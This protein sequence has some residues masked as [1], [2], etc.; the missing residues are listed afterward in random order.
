MDTLF[1]EA[2]ARLNMSLKRDGFKVD[3]GIVISLLPDELLVTNTENELVRL[4]DSFNFTTSKTHLVQAIKNHSNSNWAAANGQFRTFIESLLIEIAHNLNSSSTCSDFGSAQ[5]ELSNLA[6][7][8]LSRTLNEVSISTNPL[9]KPY[10]GGLW[11]RLHA[12]GSHPGTSDEEDSTFRYHTV[13]VF[14][15]YLLARLEN[16]TP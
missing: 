2:Y 16:R 6:S 14:A 13:S 1:A 9:D 12:A 11:K 4:L 7:P 10:V 8:F 15:R 5:N 3:N